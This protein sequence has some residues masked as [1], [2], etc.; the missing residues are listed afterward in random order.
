[1]DTS[2]HISELTDDEI[3][4]ILTQI[5]AQL[6]Q[7]QDLS[8]ADTERLMTLVMSGKCPDMLLSAILVAWRMK[9]EN[10]NEF[11]TAAKFMRKIAHKV[12]ISGDNVVDIVG[13]GGDGANLFNVSTAS[14]FVVASLGAKVAK[15][16]STGVS[17]SSGASDLLAQAGVNLQLAPDQLA[18]T[19]QSQNMCFMFAPNHHPAMRHAKNVRATLKMRTIFN[20]LGPLTNPASAPNTLLGVFDQAWCETLAQALGEIGSRHVWV[21]ASDDGLDEISLAA[22]TKVAEY[23]NG[24]ITTFYITPEE[25]GVQR[26]SL[27]GLSVSSPAQSL[28]LIKQALDPNHSDPRTQK[29]RDII[30]LNAGVALYLSGTADSPKTGVSLAKEALASGQALQKMHDFATFTQSFKN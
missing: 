30:A 9:G 3:S 23:K 22:P 25:L 29:A 8:P 20:V 17:S 4:S 7:K 15:H 27:D 19:L 26:Q 2:V 10:A 14:S 21:V 5:L 6:T 28:E 1:M 16:G 24:Q 11:A 13:T 12:A 18:Q